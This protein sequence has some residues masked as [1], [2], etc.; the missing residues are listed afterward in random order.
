VLRINF[1]RSEKRKY[2]GAN[3]FRNPVHKCP[4]IRS[5]ISE[6]RFEIAEI[7]AL[8][9]IRILPEIS[10]ILEIRFE[11]LNPA[12]EHEMPETLN[13]D[14]K[15]LESG[16]ETK[17]IRPEIRK[18]WSEI[19]ETQLGIAEIH[20]TRPECLEIRPKTL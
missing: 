1:I 14:V 19:H 10:V 20:E 11:K 17:K 15:S 12:C 18:F 13:A 2:R 6:I 4:V 3:Y 16:M 5:E 8:L 9:E 7:H